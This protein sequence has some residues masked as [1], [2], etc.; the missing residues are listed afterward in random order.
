MDGIT[1]CTVLEALYDRFEAEA[2]DWK[3]EAVCKKGCA[4]CCRK[5]S[6]IEV[7]TLEGWRIRSF[8]RGLTPDVARDL[9]SRVAKDRKNREKGR[10][11]SCPF[12]S[13]DRICRIY[14]VRPFVCRRLYSTEDC[15]ISGPV[16]HKEVID[17]GHRFRDELQ[18]LDPVGYSGHLSFVLGLLEESGFRECW[19]AGR[20]KPSAITTLI[21]KYKLVIHQSLPHVKQRRAARGLPQA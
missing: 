2:R 16:L 8:L 21:R 4:D 12:L 15:G 5:S 17:L 11:T 13:S 6:V 14:P 10:K 18:C 9:Y 7:T 19:S 1:A 20:A 3:A